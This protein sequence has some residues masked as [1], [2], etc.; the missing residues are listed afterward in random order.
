ML[1]V[2]T[3]RRLAPALAAVGLTLAWQPLVHA[4]DVGALEK[5]LQD[6]ARHAIPRTVLVRAF[7]ADG[8]MGA[9]SGAIISPDGLILTCAHV[10]EIGDRIEVAT[11]DG[12]T[13]KAT[14]LGRNQRQDYALLKVDAKD[15][16]TFTLGDSDTVRPG[17]WV[18]ALG[19][20]GGPYADL[21]P[22]FAAGKVRGLNR[23]LPVGMMQKY[24]NDA[25]M[26]DCPIFAGDSGGPLLN[27][28][29][30]LVGINGAIVMINEMAFAVPLNQIM[31]EMDAMK[32]GDVIAGVP[33]GPEAWQDMQD[34][35]SP[36]DYQRM[37]QRAMKNLPK[38]FGGEDSP[39]GQLFGEDSPLKG[40]FGGGGEMPDLSELFGGGGEMPDLGKL[41]GGG[42]EMPD[43]SKL[44]GEDSPFKDLFG[45]GGEM[46][47]LS[48]LFGEDSPLKGLFGGGGEAPDLGKLFGDMFGGGE[49]PSAR[50]QRP[51]P[52]PAPARPQGTMGLRAA[53]DQAADL[54]GVLIDEVAPGGPAAA[55]GLKRGDV[56]VAIDG[57]PTPDMAALKRA[58]EGKAPGARVE[59]TVQRATFVDT[60]LVQARHTF[61][62]TLGR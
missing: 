50:P 22:A 8:R 56:V 13:Y 58:L 10:I 20:P 23:K 44:F 61:Q 18:V 43:L 9:G 51:A 47:D 12:T 3:S 11:P 55:A 52:A 2:P 4:Q 60:A 1:R 25:I 39:L 5:T 42:G 41:F 54:P 26:T 49:D 29:G 16:P 30:E 21:Q 27:M 57:R 35:I 40:L 53:Q 33:A 34:I 48:K 31:R 62:I 7:V 32:R 17:D 46:P 14:V 36:E 45:G 59:V 6:V 38:L 24:Y 19:H 37:M 15:L 28:K